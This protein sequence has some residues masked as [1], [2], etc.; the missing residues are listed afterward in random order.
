MVCLTIVGWAL[1]WP[2]AT[3][4]FLNSYATTDTPAWV[5]ALYERKDLALQP[6]PGRAQAR[7][8]VVGGSGAL[9]GI[10]AE[11][12][13]QK[14]GVRTI[15]YATHA[16]LNRYILY[17]ARQ[18]LRP[19]DSVL[20]CPEYELWWADEVSDIE[21]NYAITY[22]KRFVWPHGGTEALRTL[23]SVPGSSYYDSSIGWAKRL[24]ERYQDEG[25]D[26]NVATLDPN[27]DLRGPIWRRAFE[28]PGPPP[29][30]DA[31]KTDGAHADFR[32]FAQW[33]RSNQVRVF[34]SWPNSCRPD[35]A[36]SPEECIT[37]PQVRALFQSWGWILLN[38]PG[39]T[40]FPPEWFSDTIY[41]VDPGCRRIRTEA[42]IRRLR[43]FYG[44]T[45]TAQTTTGIYLVTGKTWWL[46]PG[47]AFAG[48]PDVRAKYLMPARVDSP[49]AITPGELA[50]WSARGVPIWFDDPTVESMLP[51]GAWDAREVDSERQSLA[52]WL[53]RY[54]RHLFLMTRAGRLPGTGPTLP[55]DA[56]P[57]TVRAALENPGQA[58]VAMGTGPW[59]NV[60]RIATD[61]RVATLR[62][63]LERLIGKKVP[64]L[65]LSA[66]ADLAD[67][68]ESRISVNGR[69]FAATSD[70]QICVVVIEPSEGVVADAAIFAGG[71]QKMLW[72]MKQLVARQNPPTPIR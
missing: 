68:G 7:L 23:Y 52:D 27:G 15:N 28:V 41:H 36:P 54:D 71:E 50:A 42:L 55:A 10:D 3:L 51:P 62:I 30:P 39:E 47:N 58:V 43:P 69:R 1:V 48:Q 34:Y 14:L 17:R 26:Y 20:L 63:A 11:L 4:G 37:P 2:F 12:I 44:L 25:V 49:D 57:P 33:A 19:G 31:L 24:L 45:P 40:W 61:S 32:D 59:K 72:S 9:F 64:H 13:Q 65:M 35:P 6:A 5:Q 18:S 56:L 21:W 22:D 29:F 67:G 53:K 60:L 16:G 8:V 38:D 46:R 70:G 66:R